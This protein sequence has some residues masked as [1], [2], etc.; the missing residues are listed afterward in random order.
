MLIASVD[1]G[2]LTGLIL[3]DSWTKEVLTATSDNIAEIYDRLLTLRPETVILEEQ[4]QN[5][6]LD[7]TVMGY[8]KNFK[9][10]FPCVMISP[11]SWKPLAEAREWKSNGDQHIKDAYNMLRYWKFTVG[12]EDI[13]DGLFGY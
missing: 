10:Y 4:P 3:Y 5:S 13:G 11:S 8:F 6:R 2:E 9:R 1:P 7:E 12:R